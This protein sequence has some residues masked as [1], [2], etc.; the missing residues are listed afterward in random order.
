M[1]CP[2][3]NPLLFTLKFLIVLKK[4]NCG[5]ESNFSLKS[6]E[7]RRGQLISYTE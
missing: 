7:L 5:K 3:R 4:Q 1:V 6:K 2:L